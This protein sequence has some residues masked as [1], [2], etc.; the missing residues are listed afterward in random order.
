[1]SARNVYT[2]STNPGLDRSRAAIDRRHV[3]SGAL[4]LALPKLEGKSSGLRNVF[5]DWELST[6]VQASSGYPYTIFVGNVPGLSGN[7]SLTGTGYTGA[8]RPD[9]TGE[10]CHLS[11]SGP[12]WFN[13]AAFTIDN[14]V[15]GTNGNAGRHICDGPGFF[16]VD[17]ALY[18]NI[19]LGKRVALQLRAEMFNVFNRTNFLSED[20]NVQTTW[21]PQ[22]VVFDTGDPTTATRVISA[23]PAGGFGLLNKAADPRQMQLGI[24]LIF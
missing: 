16:R 23:T 24:K 5:G 15:I 6:I 4:V 7:G 9:L 22:N 13:P 8:Q 10:P 11:G 17:A 20:G 18:K 12:A 19:K 21:T 14:H 2:D 1:M 3:F